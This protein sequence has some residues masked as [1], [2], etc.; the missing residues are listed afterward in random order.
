MS[1]PI[2]LPADVY[3]TLELSALAFGGI[4]CGQWFDPAI[5]LKDYTPVCPIGHLVAA[6]AIPREY[7]LTPWSAFGLNTLKNDS[8]ELPPGERIAFAEWCRRLNVV[9]GA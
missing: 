3:D 2:V 1:T 4:G 5:G 7:G 6:R 9:R 8:L